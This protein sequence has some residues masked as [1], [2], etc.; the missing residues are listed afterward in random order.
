M[1]GV[2]N[3]REGWFALDHAT[4]NKFIAAAAEFLLADEVQAQFPDALDG[5][6]DL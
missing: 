6:H 4:K 2:T 3:D 1:E 5:L